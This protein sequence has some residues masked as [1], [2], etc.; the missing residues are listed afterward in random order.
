[1]LGPHIRE[2]I[3]RKQVPGHQ[4][5]ADTG[6]I[7]NLVPNR[8]KQDQVRNDRKY[9]DRAG[10]IADKE[11]QQREQEEPPGPGSAGEHIVIDDQVQH[12]QQDIEILETE[13]SG[14]VLML[15]GF[16]MDR[17]QSAGR[18]KPGI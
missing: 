11:L 15:Y 8:R 12:R 5:E 18:Q 7:D 3:G 14:T 6:K 1:M 9:T 10:R 17:R 13:T 4:G 2:E 16:S